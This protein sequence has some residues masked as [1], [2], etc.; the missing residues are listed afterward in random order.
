MSGRDEYRFRMA[1]LDSLTGISEKVRATARN[2]VNLGKVPVTS[3]I[4]ANEDG[5]VIF[6]W[7]QDG[8]CYEVTI[9]PVP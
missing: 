4:F 2:W 3:F 9:G 1:R 6:E 5:D 8:L 7:E